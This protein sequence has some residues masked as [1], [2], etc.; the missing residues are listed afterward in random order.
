MEEKKKGRGNNKWIWAVAIIIVLL[1][2]I[3]AI[4]GNKKI[5]TTSGDGNVPET[6]DINS[7]DIGDNPD[8]GVEDFNSLPSSQE[9]ISS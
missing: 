7:L 2:L 6:G 5:E 1:V 4:K 9:A 8:I 3:F